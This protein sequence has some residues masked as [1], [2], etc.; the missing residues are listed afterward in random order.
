MKTSIRSALLAAALVASAA[1]PAEEKHHPPGAANAAPPAA[2][3]VAQD[4]AAALVE[5]EVRR[6]DRAQAKLTLK[7]GEIRN[8][9]MPPMT[10]VFKVKDPAILDKLKVGDRVRFSADQ[11][12]GAF[13]VTRIEAAN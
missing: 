12:D 6:V 4:G 5:G 8:L 10:M 11:V 9:E 1:A 7:H 13:T 3:P 2:S